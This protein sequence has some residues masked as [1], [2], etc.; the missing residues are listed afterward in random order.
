VKNNFIPS[1]NFFRRIPS[2]AE[3]L[4]EWVSYG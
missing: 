2:H 1:D 4:Y 3:L